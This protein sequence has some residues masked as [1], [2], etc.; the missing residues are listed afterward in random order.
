MTH[1]LSPLRIALVVAVGLS[2]LRFQDTGYLHLT[3]V[4]ALDY[5][6]QRRGPVEPGPDVVIAAIDNN[7]ID[8][9]GRWPWPRTIMAQL[10]DR[11]AAGKPRAIGIDILFSE[12]TGFSDLGLRGRPPTV[13]PDAWTDALAALAAHDVELERSLRDA[14]NVVLGY[15]FRFDR[16][17][18]RTFDSDLQ[19]YNVIHSHDAA[20]KVEGMFEARAVRPNLRR[21]RNAAASIG[22]FNINPDIGDGSVRRLQMVVRHEDQLAIPLSLATLQ[23]ALDARTEIQIGEHVVEDVAIGDLDIATDEIGNVLIN[24][25][26]PAETFPHYPATAIIDGDVPSSAFQDKIVLIGVTATAVADVRV[27]PFAEVFPGVEIHA[28]VIDNILQQDFIRRP[29]AL[30]VVDAAVLF[31]FAV[32]LGLVL[33]RY[34]GV[35]G[36]LIT[37]ATFVGYLGLSQ[38]LFVAT[39][40]A[41]SLI[42][43]LLLVVATYAAI[44]VFQY[45]TEE[46]E[47]R[48]VRRALDLYLS[49][50]MANLVSEQ[51]ERLTLGGE[52]R[53]L[54]VFFSDIRGFTSISEQLEPEQLVDLLNA[55]LGE[56]TDIVF[57]HDGMLDKYIGDAV[58]AVWGAP[59]PQ[60][61]HAERA[62]L[63]TL[64]MTRRLAELNRRWR[65]RG[66]PTIEIGCGLNSG[67]MV[68]GN[69]GSSRHLSLTV[70]GDNVN[71]GSRLEGTN[72]LYGT[73][74]IA[75]ESTV[76]AAADV[77]TARELDL[78]R[79]KGKAAPV[80]IYE[81]LGHRHEHSH[82]ESLIERF[83]FGLAAFREREWSEAR[84]HFS[85]VLEKTPTDAPSRLYLD[86][87]RQYAAHPPPNDWTGVTVLEGK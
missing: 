37:I 84:G 87:C 21:F 85:A 35:N 26:G 42:Y 6:L 66:W 38:Q 70:M 25:R 22:Y 19:T 82:W 41:L 68:F 23:T 5:R 43:P 1:L 73:S 36:S 29:N 4:R 58:M 69:M 72:K 60:P 12:P 39:G 64:A 24:Y 30:I 18:A 51:P 74:I 32:L 50:S 16:R 55:Y 10:I 63:A 14:G 15:F 2:V 52:K 45:V 57:E 61:D 80:R 46:R 59:L 40:I 71:L 3:D 76:A 13:E 67:P 81:I 54:T 33:Q 78:V 65:E 17:A 11:I 8:H 9:Q 79:V 62:C 86:R 44:V 7:S 56:M 53:D 49:P 28:T 20:S 83:G 27:T 34:R 47:K 77:I 75:S 31:G 48:K